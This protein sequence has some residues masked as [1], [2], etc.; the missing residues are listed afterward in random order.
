VNN[1]TV[2]Y[3]IILRTKRLI[4]DGVDEVMTCHP[5]TYN[6]NYHNH[7]N[8]VYGSIRGL[9]LKRVKRYG[10]PYKPRPTVLV[11]DDS[12]EIETPDSYEKALCQFKQA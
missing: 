7:A 11:V 4:E 8:K 12:V 9:S 3:E 6:E 5:M 10:D 2:S 1:P